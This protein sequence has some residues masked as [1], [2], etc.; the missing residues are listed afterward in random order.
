LDTE[1]LIDSNSACRLLLG[2]VEAVA[3]A[4]SE[5]DPTAAVSV[6]FP[7]SD[8]FARLAGFITKS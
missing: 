4:G 2:G 3:V 1:S 7:Q 8:S 6:P 5:T